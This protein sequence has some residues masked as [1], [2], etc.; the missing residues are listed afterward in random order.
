MLTR[1]ISIL[2]ILST[3]IA[4]NANSN[5][6]VAAYW[7][8]NAGGSQSSLGSYCS[9]SAAD[10]IILSFM[11]GF[12]NLELNFANQCSDTY[13]DG[14]LHC[15][16]IGSDIKSCQSQGKIVLLSLGGATG[17]YGFSSDSDAQSFAT[18]LWNK[19]GGGSDSERPFDDAVIDG[20]DFDMENK[21]QTGYAAMAA[22]LRQYF[23]SDSSKSYYLSAAPQCPYPDESVGDILSQVDI[24][25]AF[26]QFYNNY[27]SLGG[28]FNWDTWSSY[29]KSTSP[30]KNIKLY[31]G[32]PG[33]TA[34]AGSGYADLSTVQQAVSSIKGDPSFGGISI[35][36]ISSGENDGFLSGCKN[37]LGSSSGGS[38]PSYSAPAFSAP[39]TV[40]PASSASPSAEFGY[41]APAP[42]SEAPASQEPSTSS[43][44]WIPADAPATTESDEGTTTV[45]T[46]QTLYSTSDTPRH[47]HVVHKV[48]VTLTTTVLVPPPTNTPQL[49]DSPIQKRDEVATVSQGGATHLTTRLGL[50]LF[51]LI[52]VLFI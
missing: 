32:L 15:S 24:D 39:S 38:A 49:G 12:P 51:S 23:N 46:L 8:Q 22:K 37:A 30:N 52:S 16:Q 36:D 40:V 48:Y 17:N 4:F 11:N 41:P 14:L 13:G 33:S 7:G 10:I 28:S 35:W 29:A 3:V 9:S 2:T 27:C 21:L 1:I 25:F 19:F 6:N 45:T 5:S 43:F 44:Q 20:F 50:V 31:L 42:S 18:T 26:I 34:S 47:Q